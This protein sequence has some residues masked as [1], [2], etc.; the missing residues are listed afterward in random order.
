[1]PEELRF[2]MRSALYSLVIGAIYWFVSYEW[3]GAV[4]LVGAGVATGVLL[5]VI[6][7]QLRSHGQRLS[8]RPWSWLLLTPASQPSHWTDE[9]GRLPGRSAAP[10]TASF[11]LA[12]AALGL[13]FG[14]ALIVAAAVPIVVGLRAWLASGMAEFAALEAATAGG[15][16]QSAATAVEKAPFSSA[17]GE[18]PA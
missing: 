2:L 4:M 15:D 5:L 14:P 18:P 16:R 7:A 6:S 17:P 12:L 3:A 13:V 10:L 8:G 1:M 11:G 9:S